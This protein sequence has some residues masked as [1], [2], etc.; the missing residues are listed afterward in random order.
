[1]PGP[2]AHQP[3]P[4]NKY[5]ALLGGYQADKG[6]GA[7]GFVDVFDRPSGKLLSSHPLP[8]AQAAP[9]PAPYDCQA[10]LLDEALLVTDV[11]GFYVFGSAP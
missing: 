6:K 5:F 7:V 10:K 4:V 3:Y 8:S 11:N 2:L 9:P 1:V